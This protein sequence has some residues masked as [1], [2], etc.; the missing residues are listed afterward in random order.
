MG[1]CGDRS[2]ARPF[3]RCFVGIAN[4]RLGGNPT[5]FLNALGVQV[6]GSSGGLGRPLKV[7]GLERSVRRLM[8][9]ETHAY[10]NSPDLT[11]STTSA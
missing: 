6:N 3:W 7:K 2:V 9:A 10:W 4:A 5:A 8:E 1:R 11:L